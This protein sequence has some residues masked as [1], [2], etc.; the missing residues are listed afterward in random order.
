VRG[1]LVENPA[2]WERI[3]RGFGELLRHIRERCNDRVVRLL[4]EHL[5]AKNQEMTLVTMEVVEAKD[6]RKAIEL[7]LLDT[8]D[9]GK[10]AQLQQLKTEAGS[11]CQKVEDHLTKLYRDADLIRNKRAHVAGT[12]CSV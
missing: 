5:R 1:F 11:R 2:T 10:L 8:K 4:G 7:Q 3:A 12:P 6:E 9:Q